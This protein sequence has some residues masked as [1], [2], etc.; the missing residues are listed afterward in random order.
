MSL[1]IR[2]PTEDV[3]L[4]DRL[5]AVGRARKAA[6][7]VAAGFAV[8]AVGLFFVTL[9]GTLDVWLHLPATVR[10]ILLVATL[11]TV[12]ALVVRRLIPAFR[13]PTNPLAVAMRLESKYPDLNDAVA[14]AV[15]FESADRRGSPRFRQVAA[16]R[17][18]NLLKRCDPD[19]I[20]PAGRAWRAFWLALL[21]LAVVL[22][23]VLL[24]AGRAGLAVA[25]FA[26]PFGTHPWPKEST[27]TI[28]EPAELPARVAKGDAVTIRFAVRGVIPPQAELRLK[29]GDHAE[30]AEPVVLAAEEGSTDTI[31]DVVLDPGRAT[32]DF[33]FRV[34]AHDA[35]TGWQQVVVAPPPRLVPWDDRPSP[36]V[37]VTYPAYTGLSAAD[38]PDG[39]AVV[40]VVAGT[41]IDLRAATDKPIIR[42]V[43]RPLAD[44][45]PYQ[46]AAAIAP[47]AALANPFAAM[48]EQ[49]LADSYTDDLPVIVE[50]ETRL[51]ASFVPRVAGLHALRFTD[52][53][54]L[55]GVR[56]FDFRVFPDP[57]PTVALDRPAAGKDTLILLPTASV[58]L[59]TR[60]DDRTFGLRR[61]WL[62][63]R[64]G[65]DGE[66]R[67]VPLV[68]FE[69]H[70]GV[71]T[72]GGLAATVRPSPP[73]AD[74]GR[75]IKLST[76]VKPDGTPPVDGDVITL[77]TAAVDWDD[78]T[79]PKDPG[80]SAE[81]TIHVV[82]RQSLD[83]VV[84]KGLADLR[85]E[86]RK[87]AALHQDA[88]RKTQDAAKSE[89]AGAEVR[90]R[91]AAA[92]QAERE[93][94]ARVGDP[95]D[96]VR[97]KAEELRLAA[98]ANGAANTPA[99]QKAEAI[100]AA[101]ASLADQHLDPLEPVLDAARAAADRAGADPAAA[102][103][104]KDRLA[105][106][107]AKQAMAA[108]EFKKVLEQLDRWGGAAEVRGDARDIK[109]EILSAGAAAAK[110][111][112]GLKPGATPESLSPADKAELGKVADRLDRAADDATALL[113]KAG[114]IAAEKEKQA[115]DLR[116]AAGADPYAAAK[117]D[118]ATAEAQALRDAVQ[119]AGGQAVANDARA[120]AQALRQNRPGE[121]ATARQSAVDR[122]DKLAASLAEKGNDPPGADELAKK[123][124]EAAA[125]I[126]KLKEQQDELRK[127]AKAAE[128]I[129]DPAER[130]AAFEKLA[131]EQE[132]LAK[133]AEQ[134]AE[135]L[136]RD[137]APKAADD[138]QQAVEEMRQAAKQME[139]GK[140]PEVE[141][142]DALDRLN[143]AK[144]DLEQQQKE[145]D[146][147]LS[148][149]KKE[150]L[151]EQF[152]SFRDR[153][154]AAV[155]EADR[156]TAAA[157]KAKRWDRPLLA[158]LTDLE[159]SQE[160]LSAELTAFVEKNL[161]ELPVFQRMATQAAEAMTKA[162]ARLADR[163][164]DAL[165]AD[166]FDPDAE[167]VAHGRVA[168]P[169]ALALKRLDQILD[170]VKP[171][172]KKPG[173]DA[174]AGGDGGGGDGGPK[175]GGIPAIA[176]LKALRALQA[177]LVDRTAAFHAENP[178]PEKYTDDQKDE[179]KD[180]EQGQRE[181]AELFEKL[182]SLFRPKLDGDGQ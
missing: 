86:V 99:G 60:A 164:D 50:N 106:A 57:T 173:G 145:A 108:A 58:E 182:L 154:A 47:L 62:E 122:L 100:A 27:I 56:L 111:L 128:Q 65:P 129:P 40:E 35:D 81:T 61:L 92:D 59:Q 160:R 148:R 80:R 155:A 28:L 174:P 22:P 175:Q 48:G 119:N 7:V 4:P 112:A 55:T 104:L 102:K 162:A 166:G 151:A 130:K 161:G 159:E 118:G 20:V 16:I 41:R 150:E 70:A 77:R 125:E 39:A 105:D 132:E 115:A 71:A 83:A 2:P 180:L 90:E 42:A 8:V 43:L 178:D 76:F 6:G 156:L 97:A 38:M 101:L 123:H 149:E 168:R 54:G 135:R 21:A 25:R 17:A 74:A 37:H 131:K 165:T 134:Q 136:T 176:Q 96:G 33:A 88:T 5:K 179:L 69:Q 85:P 18:E 34:T 171:D 117:A 140:A 163:K 36:L 137:K 126:D 24:N 12:G 91:L 19:S 30:S 95:R 73:T 116:A 170:A 177:D 124:K 79:I 10:S 172:E 133:K 29:F 152:K 82:S 139:Q 64:V 138:L 98:R 1:L 84:Q 114:K 157:A 67:A 127:K 144:K 153:Q 120:A 46:S 141:Q 103:E 142:Q 167:K 87:A 66:F 3:Y 109:S 44:P 75:I 143:D 32:K 11:G 158:S 68:D 107:G 51:T 89:A 45:A 63:Y 78:V 110:P 72:A 14:S 49:L 53:T 181:V 15:E 31:T 23:L 146:D 26:D 113:D 52:A 147:Q 94:A 13:E 9:A 169:L 93:A 121:S